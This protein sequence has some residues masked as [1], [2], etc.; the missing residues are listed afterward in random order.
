MREKQLT[1]TSRYDR[2]GKLSGETPQAKTRSKVGKTSEKNRK[3]S[4]KTLDTEIAS[5]IE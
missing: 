2:M 1:D 3:K 5:M 4:E